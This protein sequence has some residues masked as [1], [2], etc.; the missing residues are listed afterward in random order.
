MHAFLPHR[1][2]EIAELRPVTLE[3][4]DK[5]RESGKLLSEYGTEISISEVDQIAG[6]PVIGD[7]ISR[8]PKNHN[9]QWLVAKD[10]F[11]E[12]FEPMGGE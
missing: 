9:D 4:I 7:M 5:F 10:Y 6:S 11:L 8:N 2:K 1:R 3:D 12:N